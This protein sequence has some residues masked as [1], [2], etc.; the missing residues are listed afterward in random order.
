VVYVIGRVHTEAVRLSLE[1]ANLNANPDES[2]E[3]LM[4][5]AMIGHTA[6][7]AYFLN[8]GIPVNAVDKNGR[9]PLIEAVFGGHTDT[10]EELLRRGADVNAQ[11]PDGWTALMEAASKSRVDLVRILLAHGADTQIKGANG[12][13]ALKATARGNT[14]ISRLLRE[15][16]AS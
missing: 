12:W 10:T 4:R 13:T 7:V 9:I 1:C 3:A 6:A 5:A 15:A 8:N 14:E 11:D 16:G 2:L